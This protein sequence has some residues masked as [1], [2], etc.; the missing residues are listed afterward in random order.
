MEVLHDICD[1]MEKELKQVV[2]RGT[3]NGAQEMDSVHHAM[4]TLY[5]ATVTDAMKKADREGYSER[6]MPRYDMRYGY[7][8]HR[9]YSENSYGNDSYGRYNDGYS[10]TDREELMRKRNEIDRKLGMM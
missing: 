1:L 2:S 7:G 10:R 3:I 4:E 8:D 6:M 9:M 5:Y